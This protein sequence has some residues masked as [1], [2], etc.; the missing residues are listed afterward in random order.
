MPAT[1]SRRMQ[2]WR[3]RRGSSASPMRRGESLAKAP[4]VLFTEQRS[5]RWPIGQ[6]GDPANPPPQPRSRRRQRSGS[7]PD[8]VEIEPGALDRARP[9]PAV[10]ESGCAEP[11]DECGVTQDARRGERC[12]SVGHADPE[13]EGQP[14]QP[15]ASSGRL[16]R[17]YFSRAPSVQLAGSR[18]H[19]A[20]YGLFKTGDAQYFA[21]LMEAA[22]A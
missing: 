6:S 2:C 7:G 11:G 4:H 17:A 22:K 15:R 10:D 8:H 20:W 1:S 19:E 12:R 14:H 13:R 18:V 16:R 9:E 5:S 21:A 3:G